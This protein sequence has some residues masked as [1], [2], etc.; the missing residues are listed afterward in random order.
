M[1]KTD[2]TPQNT[3]IGF[4]NVFNLVEYLATTTEYI[5]N[6]VGIPFDYGMMI[7]FGSQLTQFD[8][9]SPGNFKKTFDIDFG[10]PKPSTKITPGTVVGSTECIL[11]Q[12]SDGW[13]AAVYTMFNMDYFVS[14]AGVKYP[15][16]FDLQ[17]TMYQAGQT[18]RYAINYIV[19]FTG[20][21]ARSNVIG[22]FKQDT[23]NFMAIIKLQFKSIIR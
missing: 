11:W 10:H 20:T 18:A 21:G 6:P 9:I 12:N 3:Y 13:D 15:L 22:S 14:G 7:N 1:P 16:Q 8:D 5:V 2:D 19:R 4:T 23:I 17:F